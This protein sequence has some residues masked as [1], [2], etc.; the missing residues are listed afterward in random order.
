MAIYFIR[1]SDYKV[2]RVIPSAEQV[3]TA[4]S[5]S[6]QNPYRLAC[7]YADGTVILWDIE[8]EKAEMKFTI[9]SSTPIVVEF[10]PFDKEGLLS[11]SENGTLHN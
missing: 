3:I 5:A 4:I 8:K 7:A 10:C 2:E 9:P 11:V 1:L 6:P